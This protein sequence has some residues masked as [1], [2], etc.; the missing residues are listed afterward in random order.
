MRRKAD[1]HWFFLRLPG[2]SSCCRWSVLERLRKNSQSPR[3][4]RCGWL[5]TTNLYNYLPGEGKHP[6]LR[7]FVIA[8]MLHSMIDLLSECEKWDNAVRA[9]DP[10]WYRKKLDEERRE[11]SLQ[12]PTK[13]KQMSLKIWRW[14][15]HEWSSPAF[16]VNVGQGK[17]LKSVKQN[18][19]YFVE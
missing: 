2:S 15:A 6:R 19:S 4:S 12:N 14:A 16:Y 3:V 10:R 17:R 8:N 1:H 13:H 18:R 9:H 7:D 5:L 11:F